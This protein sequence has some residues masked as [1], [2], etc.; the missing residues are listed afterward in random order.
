MGIMPFKQPYALAEIIAGQG[1]INAVSFKPGKMQITLSADETVTL[2]IAQ[3]YQS[4]SRAVALPQGHEL[5]IQSD[6]LEGLISL[7]VPPGTTAVEIT[8]VPTPAQR[9]G[10]TLGSLAVVPLVGTVLVYRGGK[11]AWNLRR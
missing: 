7:E 1:S 4:H 11:F 2:R 6:G 5:V 3:N 8:A 10:K 9:L